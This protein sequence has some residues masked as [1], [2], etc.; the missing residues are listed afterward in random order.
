MNGFSESPS[1]IPVFDS[2]TIRFGG[3]FKKRM[4][5]WA[6]DFTTKLSFVTETLMVK[7]AVV[8]GVPP[9]DLGTACRL[10]NVAVTAA[11]VPVVMNVVD[12]PG[13]LASVDG[14]NVT[15]TRCMAFVGMS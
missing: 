11:G 8:P 14:D 6:F 12:P 10:L 9:P 15:V 4:D 1:L 2:D 13:K 5:A 7:G 3:E